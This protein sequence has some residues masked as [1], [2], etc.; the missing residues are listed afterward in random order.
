MFAC[1][2]H[3]VYF[4]RSFIPDWFIYCLNHSLSCLLC[5]SWSDQ[6]SV[7][8]AYFHL[9][10]SRTVRL[11]QLCPVTVFR[12]EL[13]VSSCSYRRTSSVFHPLHVWL[14]AIWMQSE[15]IWLKLL[16]DGESVLQA[17]PAAERPAQYSPS[18][19]FPLAETQPWLCSTYCSSIYILIINESSLICHISRHIL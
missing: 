9:T 13:I 7:Y 10:T 19:H 14:R 11:Y 18:R 8:S 3:F 4:L 16:M 1:I 17:H 12:T 15:R 2:N 6:T 5:C